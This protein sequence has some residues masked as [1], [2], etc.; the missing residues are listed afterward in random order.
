MPI[1][2]NSSV[3][4]RKFEVH[5]IMHQIQRIVADFS[6]DT[7]R[8][9]G[10]NSQE[11]IVV[12]VSG[13]LDSMVLLYL[14]H[15][16]GFQCVVAH[17]NY[18]LRGTDS[19]EDE[20]L[21]KTFCEAQKIPFEVCHA[22]PAAMREGNLQ[23]N[24]RVF[25]YVFFE[26]IRVKYACRFVAVA[27]HK[28]DAVE[29]VLWKFIRG[30]YAVVPSSMK[31]QREAIIRPLMGYT[32]STL[33][34]IA[35]GYAIPWREDLSNQRSDYTRNK[36]R[37]E[38]IPVINLI[39][40]GFHDM[41]LEKTHHGSMVEEYVKKKLHEEMEGLI[42]KRTTEWLIGQVWLK[43]DGFDILR[44]G[45]ICEKWQWPAQRAEELV[46]LQQ[47]ENGKF[48][49]S[50]SWRIVKQRDGLLV[51]RNQTVQQESVILSKEDLMSGQNTITGEMV[52]VVIDTTL[53]SNMILVD[54][55]RLE[56]PLVW[57]PWQQG[58]AII[59]IGMRGRKLVSDL[60][61]DLKVEIE[62]KK[63][64]FVLCSGERILWVIGLRMSDD[65]KLTEQTKTA[66]KL[67]VK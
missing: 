48:L 56:F 7:E 15:H 47:G 4:D 43:Q 12:A 67:T 29:T 5:L 39:Q 20:A 22:D 38:I 55:D 25:R 11:R 51:L 19:D 44:A 40:P 26:E 28:D 57:R 42:E 21:V 49:E 24:A 30:N 33:R 61:I 37:N 45:F 50:A 62:Q 35:L 18:H 31:R 13:G 58:D 64:V 34:D 8:S 16:A 66:I 54:A 32:K 36:I 60:L 23:D 65:F 41:L 46:R 63:N 6:A 9:F 27:H 10:V 2:G 52:P 53:P 1:E 14:M 59:P 17:V 3:V